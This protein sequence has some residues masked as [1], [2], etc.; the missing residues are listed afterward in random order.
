MSSILPGACD[1]SRKAPGGD[2]RGSSTAEIVVILPVLMLLITVGL[3]FALWALASSATSD[4]VAQGGAALRADGG[5]ATAARAVALQELQVL[6]SGLVVQPAVSVG[7]LPD[8]FASLSASGSVPSLLPGEHLIVS[9]E[10]IG[11]D[12]QFRASG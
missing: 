6:A 8:S 11:P 4:S 9:A 10:S 3:Q 1:R 7:T 12:Q 2:E 5:T